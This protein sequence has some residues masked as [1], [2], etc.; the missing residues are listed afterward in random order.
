M[1]NRLLA[2]WGAPES[3]SKASR[4]PGHLV[5]PNLSGVLGISQNPAHF[6]DS[7]LQLPTSASLDSVRAQELRVLQARVIPNEV[8]NLPLSTLKADSSAFGLE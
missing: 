2:A 6:S 4:S 8:R 5:L 7:G 3:F 1:G